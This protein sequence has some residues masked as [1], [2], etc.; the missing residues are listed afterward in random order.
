M[1]KNL[2]GHPLV[3]PA[4]GD[5]ANGLV[6]PMVGVHPLLLHVHDLAVFLLVRPARE[7]MHVADDL[8]VEVVVDMRQEGL[9]VALGAVL[10]LEDGSHFGGGGVGI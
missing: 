10:E 2:D 3:V 6:I 5:H 8:E 9:A 1:I 4:A 7:R